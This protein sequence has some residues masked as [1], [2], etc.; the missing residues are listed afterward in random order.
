MSGKT[1]QADGLL[2]HHDVDALGP[3][4]LETAIEMIRL[5]AGR[6]GLDEQDI[7]PITFSLDGWDAPWSEVSG[8][9]WDG[10]AGPGFGT[11]KSQYRCL[12]FILLR[13]PMTGL[14]TPRTARGVIARE[15]CHL[16]WWGL[17]SGREFDARVTALLRGAQFPP[18][19]RA[20][21][22]ATHRLVGAGREEWDAWVMNFA[23]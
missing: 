9:S 21:T 16:R 17:R 23:H 11:A 4:V 6:A 19:G 15:I 20:W 7:P 12:V 14:S 3:G 2:V 13:C 10:A 18:R 8:W 22:P 1:I 5:Y